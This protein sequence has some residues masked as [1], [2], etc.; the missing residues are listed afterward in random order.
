MRFMF[1]LLGKDGVYSRFMYHKYSTFPPVVSRGNTAYS[2]TRGESS[3][4]SKYP[5]HTPNNSL[6]YVGNGQYF[7][8]VIVSASSQ[9]TRRLC[10]QVWISS[11]YA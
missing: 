8:A 6:S 11:R 9:E 7:S 1:F 5:T 10:M 2:C 3:F 4:S